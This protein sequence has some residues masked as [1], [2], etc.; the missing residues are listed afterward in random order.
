MPSALAEVPRNRTE[1]V[2]ELLHSGDAYATTLFVLTADRLADQVKRPY[3]WMEWHPAALR[4]F[5]EDEFGTAVPQLTVDRLMAA[6]AVVGTDQFHTDPARFIELA[7][8]LSGSEAGSEFDPADSVECA[9][10]VTESLLLDPPDAGEEKFSDDVRAYIGK[11]LHDEGYITPPDV[12]RIAL[13]AD[14]S[15]KVTYSFA[16]DQ[17]LFSGIYAVQADKTAEVEAAIRAGLIDL[18]GQ[19]RS[20]PLQHG[21][22]DALVEQIAGLV[23]AQDEEES[24]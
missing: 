10:A 18:V 2:K 17:E 23:K 8:V 19:L 21:N 20:L 3:E 5:L 14:F 7:N 6:I 4:H 13:D 16:D 15:A 12:L 24:N 1:Y 9:W 22:T 11:V